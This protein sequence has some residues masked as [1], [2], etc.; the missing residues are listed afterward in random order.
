MATNPDRNE[1]LRKAIAAQPESGPTASPSVPYVKYLMEND[2]VA[3]GL[4]RSLQATVYDREL[5]LSNITKKEIGLLKLGYLR[6]EIMFDQG[7]PAMSC[8]YP[9]EIIL[10]ALPSKL[11][12]KLARSI[13]GF[14]Q[15]QLSTQ[16]I[17]RHAH[18]TG[19]G[20]VQTK[21]RWSFLSRHKTEEIKKE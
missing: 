1:D 16:T 4:P 10:A 14:Q 15:K 3:D 9:D 13:D 7:R 2:F 11:H 19:G 12:I 17:I 6:S 21:S 8:N 5:G 18:V 20:M